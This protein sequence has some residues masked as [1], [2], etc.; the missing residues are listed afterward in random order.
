M[1]R[2]VDL[3]VE[4]ILTRAHDK[5]AHVVGLSEGAQVV[6]A[7]LSRHPEIVDHAMISS[8]ILRPL[9]GSNL[10]TSGLIKLMYRWFMKPLKNNDWWIRLNM[11]YSAGIT[12]EYYQEFKRSFQ[13]TT[14]DGL[15]NMMLANLSFRLPPGLEQVKNPVLV[16]TGSKEYSQMKE[17][18]RDLLKVLPNAK[19]ISV[20]LG[21]KATLAQ[22]HNWALSA[23]D[24]FSQTVAAFI[25]DR[26]LP[27]ELKEFV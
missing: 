7:L 24:L 10:Y 12:D 22:E 17:S 19:G 8:A 3:V 9:P 23:P 11:H 15:T 13:S 4:L 5:R 25:E 16:A 6:V 21:S 14:E 20:D 27:S 18:A 1:E 26:E 2:A